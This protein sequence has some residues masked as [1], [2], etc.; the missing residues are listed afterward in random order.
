MLGQGLTIGSKV[1]DLVVQYFT[2]LD[3]A[4]LGDVGGLELA[5][6]HLN[7]KI[8]TVHRGREKF[9][10]TF[11]PPSDALSALSVQ[12]SNSISAK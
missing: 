10:Y 7:P 8:T 3:V 5:P 12:R 6:P 4:H 1:E 11:S 2:D 9:N